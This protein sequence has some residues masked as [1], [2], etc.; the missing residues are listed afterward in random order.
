MDVKESGINGNTVCQDCP[1]SVA[2]N[3]LEF[4]SKEELLAIRVTAEILFVC[5]LKEIAQGCCETR[6]LWRRFQSQDGL[7]ALVAHWESWADGCTSMMMA[8]S[9][10]V[11]AMTSSAGCGTG[12]LR[13]PHTEMPWLF[14]QALLLHCPPPAP[15][16][17]GRDYTFLIN[18]FWCALGILSLRIGFIEDAPSPGCRRFQSIFTKYLSFKR[19][20]WQPKL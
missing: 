13:I 1:G 12:M 16:I 17:T 15:C 19:E 20:I 5:A 9:W 18:H 3:S 4:R 10:R 7:I 14:F 8:I 11:L 2:V 6:K